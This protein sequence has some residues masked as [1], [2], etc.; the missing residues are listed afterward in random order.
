MK[1]N[2]IKLT[3]R[4]FV[5]ATAFP[6]FLQVYRAYYALVIHIVVRLFK[7]YPSI[8]AAYLRRGGGKGKIVPL[9]S[10]IDLAVFVEGMNQ[11]EKESLCSA[12]H[13]LVKITKV[14]D[15]Y[16]E[17]YDD[18]NSYR[19]CEFPRQY[20][21]LEAKATWKRLYGKDYIANIA[22][23][24]IKETYTSVFSEIKLW[25]AIF[26]W[27]LFQDRK[28]HDENVTQNNVCYKTV[29]EILKMDLFL[30]GGK[31]TF[32][33]NKAMKMAKPLLDENQKVFVERLEKICRNRFL[34]M[35]KDIVDDTKDFLLKYLDRTFGSSCIHS[36]ERLPR[37]HVIRVDCSEN[38]IFW[39]SNEQYYVKRLLRFIKKKWLFAYQGAYIVP[40]AHF[41]LD[42]LLLTILVDVEHLPTK[43]ELRELYQ[44][45]SKLPVEIGSRIHL[46]FLL[47]NVSFQI[48]TDY[49]N[50]PLNS[51]LTP[52]SSPD[53]FE[54]LR[55]TL[56]KVDGKSYKSTNSHVWIQLV[57][58]IHRTEKE[59]C[60]EILNSCLK[61]K[62]NTFKFLRLFWK[63]A[64]LVIISSSLKKSQL[65]FP[66]TLPSII[67]ALAE[68]GFAL[69]HR[70]EVLA[71]IYPEEITGGKNI[72]ISSLV[73]ESIAFLREIDANITQRA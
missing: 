30:K 52:S 15:L 12:Y 56:F 47:K 23:I 39:T 45:H 18:K 49:T 24:S 6:P 25:W 51:I 13:R 61:S 16:L 17:I 26:A 11:K 68:K 35:D 72:D 43:K 33:R 62:W 69:P 71:E 3:I 34:A 36:L 53:V 41:Y 37:I 42:E 2:R 54:L 4:K 67:R 70:L 9:L 46:F 21:F 60:F 58:N 65:F 10:D 40:C 64:Q 44:F 14:L 27:R 29:S 1:K 31:L 73:Q 50:K 19:V 48:D 66:L 20:R 63:T 5:L 55:R 59:T 32:S 28:Y 38:D 8:R 7:R 57:E 22:P